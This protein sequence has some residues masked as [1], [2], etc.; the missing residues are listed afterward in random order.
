M[1]SG[2]RPNLSALFL[3]ALPATAAAQS[4]DANPQMQSAR[5]QLTGSEEKRRQALANFGPV[6]TVSYGY[7]RTDAKVW[8]PDSIAMVRPSQSFGQVISR[9]KDVNSARPTASQSLMR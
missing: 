6:G 2:N 9:P 8:S 4:L 7:Q 3:A 5:A 1:L